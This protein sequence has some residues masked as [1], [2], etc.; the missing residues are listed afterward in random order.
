MGKALNNEL[1][2]VM[3]LAYITYANIKKAIVS[4][5]PENYKS[6]AKHSTLEPKYIYRNNYT[7][8]IY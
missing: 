4:N 3:M 7:I 8:A 5:I 6:R 1:I 2:S